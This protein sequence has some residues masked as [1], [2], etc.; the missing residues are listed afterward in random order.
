MSGTNLFRAQIVPEA[1]VF[2]PAPRKQ[3]PHFRPSSVLGVAMRTVMPKTENGIVMYRARVQINS[4]VAITQAGIESACETDGYIM[5]DEE[6]TDV[7]AST[8]H[9]VWIPLSMV[10]EALPLFIQRRDRLATREVLI[11]IIIVSTPTNIYI[12]SVLVSL[13]GHYTRGR[14]TDTGPLHRG[15]QVRGG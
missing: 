10:R 12:Y 3:L 4:L 1:D 7:S 9:K 14:Y 8:L 2:Q 11:I 13:P 5:S 15:L 6:V